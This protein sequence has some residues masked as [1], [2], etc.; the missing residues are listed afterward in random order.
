[1]IGTTLFVSTANATGHRIATFHSAHSYALTAQK[2]TK[3][4]TECTSAISNRFLQ[5]AGTLSS[6]VSL[7]SAAISDSS[8]SFKTT[9]KNEIAFSQSIAQAQPFTTDECLA[10]GPVVFVLRRSD[11]QRRGL[12]LSRRIMTSTRFLNLPAQ[13]TSPP[14]VAS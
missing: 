5:T 11:R 6:S 9:K 2:L 3:P 4:L 1:M 7:R 10:L 12:N 14:K 13:P 8:T